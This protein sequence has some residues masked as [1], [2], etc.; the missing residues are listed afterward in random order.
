MNDKFPVVIAFTNDRRNYTA[1][2]KVYF[3]NIKEK[4]M[5]ANTNEIS[6]NA[7]NN[8]KKIFEDMVEKSKIKV[9]SA[10]V[11]KQML[12]SDFT[13]GVVRLLLKNRSLVYT[14]TEFK[15]M[16]K[17]TMIKDATK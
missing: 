7:N 11:Y 12:D 16:L 1:V 17:S 13:G 8:L 5:R 3:T 15:S 4:W 14:I 6:S 2:K 10:N 9:L